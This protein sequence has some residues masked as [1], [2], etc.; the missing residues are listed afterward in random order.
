MQIIAKNTLVFLYF[1]RKAMR[2]AL[3]KYINEPEHHFIRLVLRQQL[4]YYIQFEYYYW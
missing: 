3:T 1:D 4:K 2:V